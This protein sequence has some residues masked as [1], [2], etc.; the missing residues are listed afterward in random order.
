LR[1]LFEQRQRLTRIQHARQRSKA[2][3]H[4]TDDLPAVGVERRIRGR[5]GVSAY[6]RR[7]GCGRYIDPGG[8]RWRTRLCAE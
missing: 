4:G 8:V 2:C 1:L 3:I 5:S 7:D 6:L